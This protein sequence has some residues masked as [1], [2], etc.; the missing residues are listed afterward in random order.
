MVDRIKKD[1]KK[2]VHLAENSIYNLITGTFY[3]LKNSKI[4]KKCGVVK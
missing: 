2:Y 4:Q 1:K 3:L